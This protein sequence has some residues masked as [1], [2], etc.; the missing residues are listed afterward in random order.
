MRGL[1]FKIF[2]EVRLNFKVNI[3]RVQLGTGWLK[4][5]VPLFRL[6]GELS[7]A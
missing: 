3:L 1:E 4:E 2:H 6:R 5:G 7:S